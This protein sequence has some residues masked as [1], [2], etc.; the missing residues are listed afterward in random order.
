MTT[1]LPF[2]LVT[3]WKTKTKR[4]GAD[5][6]STE[7]AAEVSGDGTQLSGDR[8]GLLRRGK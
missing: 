3:L 1:H 4:N 2:A 6:A 8:V 5:D 7:R